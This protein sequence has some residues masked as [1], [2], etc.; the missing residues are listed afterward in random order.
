MTKLLCF[1]ASYATDYNKSVQGHIDDTVFNYSLLCK[2]LGNNNIPISF[3]W[4]NLPSDTP[5]LLCYQ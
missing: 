4:L 2:Q 5:V 1:V 3:I